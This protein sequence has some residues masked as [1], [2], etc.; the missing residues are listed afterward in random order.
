MRGRVRVNG[1]N[2]EKMRN[3]GDQAQNEYIW[4]I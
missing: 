4:V 1:V 3:G 2:E